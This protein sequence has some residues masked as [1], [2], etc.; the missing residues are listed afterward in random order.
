MPC[1]S[2]PHSLYRYA[3][4]IDH[5]QSS[6]FSRSWNSLDVKMVLMMSSGNPTLS[7]NWNHTHQLELIIGGAASHGSKQVETSPKTKKGE[8]GIFSITILHVSYFLPSSRHAHA[9]SYKGHTYM[10]VSCN[11]YRFMLTQQLFVRAY[12][13]SLTCPMGEKHKKLAMKS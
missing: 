7:M 13:L 1:A 4:S 2:S 12:L 10:P 8:T 9:L 3:I 5:I 6:S 11:I